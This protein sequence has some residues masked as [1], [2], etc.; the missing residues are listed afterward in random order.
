[1]G[2]EQNS[3]AGLVPMAVCFESHRVALKEL[4]P[5]GNRM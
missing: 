2:Y 5:K 3:N 1:M 4:T